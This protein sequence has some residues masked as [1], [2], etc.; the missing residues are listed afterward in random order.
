[1]D[2]NY[3]GEH[4]IIFRVTS[5]GKELHPWQA[6]ASYLLTGGFVL[7]GHCG[8]G[9]VVDKVF[10]TRE[11]KPSHFDEPRTS[12]DMAMFDPETAADSGKKH[13]HL[14]YTCIREQ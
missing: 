14:G 11:A 2:I 13:M 1:M 4:P 10:G 6:Y 8:D 5:A 9:F 7:Y 12:S 3:D